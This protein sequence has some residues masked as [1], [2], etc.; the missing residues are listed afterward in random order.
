MSSRG[1]EDTTI[2]RRGAMSEAQ[3]RGRDDAR[4]ASACVPRHRVADVV[5]RVAAF[6][7]DVPTLLARYAWCRTHG[8]GLCGGGRWMRT[9]RPASAG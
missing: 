9:M 4:M 5:K 7:G 6:V 8:S 3:W 2:A 1:A